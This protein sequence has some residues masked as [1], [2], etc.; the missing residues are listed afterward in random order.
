MQKRG[1]ERSMMQNQQSRVWVCVCGGQA[2]S[3]IWGESRC[4]CVS[5]SWDVVDEWPVGMPLWS[6]HAK[7]SCHLA[8]GSPPL[9]MGIKGA[10]SHQTWPNSTHLNKT[11]LS[12]PLLS[13]FSL[14]L[15][16]ESWVSDSSFWGFPPFFF[17]SNSSEAFPF[18]IPP[19]IPSDFFFSHPTLKNPSLFTIP[20]YS[21]AERLNRWFSCDCVGRC[22]DVVKGSKGEKEVWVR[23]GE[24]FFI[25][26]YI[27]KIRKKKFLYKSNL[28]KTKE[29]TFFFFHSSS[30]LFTNG[31]R[32][33]TPLSQEE[34]NIPFEF[35]RGYQ[36]HSQSTIFQTWPLKSR[37]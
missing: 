18:T 6:D 7:N 5:A 12:P 9:C 2:E 21:K 25:T 30:F 36:L 33:K 32:W 3:R 10:W 8:P 1:E 34:R 16:L 17:N 23:K 20:L 26:I 35:P 24:R 4:G 28:L 11:L 31:V 15:C 14:S 13:L 27:K 22:L 19:Q 37:H 29:I